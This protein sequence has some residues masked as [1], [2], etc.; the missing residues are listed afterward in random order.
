MGPR[1][2]WQTRRR[3]PGNAGKPIRA[4]SRQLA[5]ADRYCG[6]RWWGLAR[7]REACRGKIGGRYDDLAPVMVLHDVHAMFEARGADRLASTEIVDAFAQM[8]D[9][10]WPEWKNGKPITPRQLAK[11]LDAYVSYSLNIKAWII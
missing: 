11:L 1:S 8:E 9:R 6:S 10:P 4:R 5:P 3:R 2:C 7:P